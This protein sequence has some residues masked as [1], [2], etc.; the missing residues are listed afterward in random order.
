MCL[1]FIY[2]YIFDVCCRV[3]VHPVARGA[4]GPPGTHAR[5]E[6]PG[7]VCPHPHQH[8]DAHQEGGEQHRGE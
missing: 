7:H 2:H 1:N 5:A 3:T 8:A 6:R 4:P